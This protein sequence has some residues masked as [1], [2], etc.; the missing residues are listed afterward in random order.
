MTCIEDY[1]AQ[2]AANNGMKN[3]IVCN[4]NK[5]SYTDLY[6]LAK[7]R[8]TQ[9][10]RSGKKSI[11]IRASQDL[12]FVI[13]YFAAHIARIPI[14]PLEKDIPDSM[15]SNIINV[16]ENSDIKEG[17][18]DI[19]FTTGTTGKQKG[20]M[21]SEDAILANAENLISAQGF[22]SELAFIICGPLNHIG[23]LSKLWPMIVIGGTTIITEGLKNTDVFFKALEYPYR[24]FATFL[25]PASIRMLLNFEKERLQNVSEK[26]DFIETG[27]AA[28]MESDMK[29]LC[30][31]F[32][33][34]RLYNTYASTE[35]GIISTYDYCNN[36]CVSG[37]VGYVM[38][39]SEVSITEDG[40]ISCKGKTLMA[41]YVGDESLTHSIL[42]D[43]T[44]YT[45]DIGSFDFANRLI[46][47]GRNGDV[48][49]IGGYKVM[50]TEVE[51]V[52]S[53]YQ[54]VSDCICVSVPHPIMGH[55]L[56]LIY[57]IKSK[58]PFDKKTFIKYIKQNMESYKVPL[59]YEQTNFI[60][61]TYNG[62][63]D[64]KYYD[65]QQS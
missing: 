36:D 61:R 18:S 5:L 32:P 27:G 45:S 15:I 43:G 9:Y 51:D 17:I 16:I 50:P 26:F 41:G 52:A 53:A 39:H 1:L 25:V 49:N 64:R 23:S 34:T 22:T 35:T 33:N 62:K 59:L 3:A 4:S 19:L 48:I 44:L 24:R 8:A 46:I 10:V 38:K 30:K 6:T 54:G 57:S 58:E 37:C 29:E 40:F 2:H 20:V 7:E 12:D 31:I 13:S 14:V 60:H 56:K 47:L 28:L 55:V 11:I 63:L 21:I 65:N 42:R